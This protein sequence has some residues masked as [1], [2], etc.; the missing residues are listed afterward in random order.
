MR[1][2]SVV[3]CEMSCYVSILSNVVWCHDMSCRVMS[4]DVM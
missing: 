3:G 2:G 1:T 4:R